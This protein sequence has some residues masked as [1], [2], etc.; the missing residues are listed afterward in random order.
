M[1]MATVT[2]TVTGVTCGHRPGAVAEAGGA[3][4]SGGD[5]MRTRISATAATAAREVEDRP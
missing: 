4:G 3:A 5:P 2:H 1:D